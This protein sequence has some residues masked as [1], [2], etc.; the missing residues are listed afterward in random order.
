MSKTNHERL[1]KNREDA[2]AFA[3]TITTG[4]SGDSKQCRTDAK[5][6]LESGDLSLAIKKLDE[7]KDNAIGITWHEQS[8][9]DNEPGVLVRDSRAMTTD[10]IKLAESA[11]EKHAIQLLNLVRGGNS[12]ADNCG[13][14]EEQK[15]QLK[16]ELDFIAQN[17]FS[18]LEKGQLGQEQ[19]QEQTSI[20]IHALEK[21]GVKDPAKALTY[22]SE[23][24]NMQDEHR[25]V[26][27]LSEAKDKAGRSHTVYEAETM[28]CGLTD[29]QKAEYEKVSTSK[30]GQPIGIEWFD[31]MPKHK[32][33][34]LR[35]LADDISKGKKVIPT[36]LVG[37]IPGIRNAYEKTTAIKEP[38]GERKTLAQRMHCG[39]P[40]TQMKN[41]D[42]QEVA[43]ENVEQLRSFM[44]KGT[45]MN[46]H[47]LNTGNTVL[48]GKLNPEQYIFKQMSE[49]AKKDGVS[50]TSTPM[51]GQRKMP[52]VR[53]QNAQYTKNLQLIGDAVESKE[54]TKDISKFLK[55][56]TPTLFTKFKRKVGIEKD[57][58]KAAREE[59]KKLKET[60][61]PLAKDLAVAIDAKAADNS[62]FE[63]K[64]NLS[65]RLSAHMTV[66]E[67]SVK[68]GTLKEHMGD[69]VNE[70]TQDVDFCK[71]GKDRTGFVEANNTRELV[72]HALD[73][74]PGSKLEK[75]NFDRQVNGNHTQQMAGMQGGTLGCH[76][77][78]KIY[79]PKYKDLQ[80]QLEHKTADHNKPKSLAKKVKNK[81]QVRAQ[82]QQKHQAHKKK[83]ET[84]KQAPAAPPP[85]ERNQEAARQAAARRQKFEKQQNPFRGAAPPPTQDMSLK[86]GGRF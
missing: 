21:A 80:Q 65:A 57:P 41:V 5:A 44:P 28:L 56:D 34:I 37:E 35:P 26:V 68:H 51:N 67:S 70:F 10:P 54:G 20:I 50:F 58:E 13:L 43:N 78:K 9:S 85:K 32:Q 61:S 22:A 82:H 59:L 18:D 12:L 55:E 79:D 52:G 73:V 53:R 30:Q 49:A 64:E 24:A 17:T 40:A 66:L 15:Q 74:E 11:Q 4:G 39:T 84:E 45:K 8:G 71:S 19:L 76:G 72:S 1:N 27:T 48:P 62:F 81:D 23:M 42:Q 31:K 6:A 3:D 25:H 83:R 63:G 16:E 36:Q 60:N 14:G 77:I 69:R 7:A 75:E 33:N 86:K 29:K 38:E 2:L 47:T 46:L